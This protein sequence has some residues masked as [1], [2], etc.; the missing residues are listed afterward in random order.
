MVLFLSTVHYEN[1][2][3]ILVGAV[4]LSD[5]SLEEGG[6]RIHNAVTEREVE[7]LKGR[8]QQKTKSIK[9]QQ[10]R[11]SPQLQSPNENNTAHNS[12]SDIEY[13]THTERYMYP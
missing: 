13:C 10:K 9:Y 4:R 3:I 8:W 6:F 11:S 1:D 5:I 12:S 2:L 7:G